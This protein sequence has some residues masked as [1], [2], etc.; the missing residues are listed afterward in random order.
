M[1]FHYVE[2][3]EFDA[4]A[5]KRM[6]ASVKDHNVTVS[7]SVDELST[8]SSIGGVILDIYRPD[9]MSI[10][11]DVS[12]VR[13]VSRAPIAFV[14]GGDVSDYRKRAIAVGAEGVFE[15][16]ALSADI[17]QQIFFNAQERDSAATLNKPDPF[18][19]ASS[20]RIA[21]DQLVNSIDYLE[22]CFASVTDTALLLRHDVPVR[23]ALHS[24]DVIK[25]VKQYFANGE[26]STSYFPITDVMIMLDRRI[27]DLAASKDVEIFLSP[28]TLSFSEI[29]KTDL[30]RLGVQHLLLTMLDNARPGD[31]IN[32]VACVDSSANETI[33]RISSTALAFL[34]RRDV[35]SANGPDGF[36]AAANWALAKACF[37][38][39]GTDLLYE[40]EPRGCVLTLR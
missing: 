11:D 9:S 18:V 23:S 4:T 6:F 40:K 33:V 3:N 14:T 13:E 17:I 20:R 19:S 12:R 5:V 2:D 24:L 16:S 28:S 25:I 27:A 1:Q 15:K 10:E 37:D 39:S 36:F 32:I 22:A 7:T 31:C 30:E 8:Y 26:A 21:V 34:G 35:S 38:L 29:G